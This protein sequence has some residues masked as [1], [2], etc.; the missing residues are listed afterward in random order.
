MNPV[1]ARALLWVAVFLVVIGPVATAYAAMFA[2]P[3]LGALLAAFPA[4]FARGRT[5]LVAVAVLALAL[6]VA[7]V[8]YPGY[9]RELD[10]FQARARAHAAEATAPT[11]APQR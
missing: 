1:S 8:H 9:R 11:R 7:S 10:R 4:V 3:L 2:F 5:R 6:I